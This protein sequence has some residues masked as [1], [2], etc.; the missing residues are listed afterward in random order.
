M[1]LALI[2]YR[3]TGKSHVARLLAG[4]LKWPLVDAD[5]HVEKQAGK[6]IADIFAEVGEPG[7]RD[8]E[9]QALIELTQGSHYVLSLGGGVILREENRQ[10]I[11]DCCF[12]VWLTASPEEI[13][14]RL[15]GDASTQARRPSLTGKSTLEEIEEVLARRIPLYRQSANLTVDTEGKSPQEVTQTILDQLPS[16]LVKKEQ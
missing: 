15:S 9:S 4:Q 2:G 11:A 5:I 6:S 10:R 1:N 7:F 13:A 14:R 8:L 16:S 3:G 12:T